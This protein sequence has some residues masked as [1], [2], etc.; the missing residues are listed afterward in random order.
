MQ[1][2]SAAPADA[3]SGAAAQFTTLLETVDFPGFVS[4][5][6]EGTF[7]A[8]VSASIEQMQAY[9]DLLNA[10]ATALSGSDDHRRMRKSPVR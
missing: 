3:E 2:K 6:I 7:N 5:L 9:A 8:I 1:K 10:V 4:S